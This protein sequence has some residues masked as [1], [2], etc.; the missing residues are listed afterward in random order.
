MHLKI[1]FI[2]VIF[3]SGIMPAMS[4]DNTLVYGLRTGM[5][6]GSF[7]GASAGSFSVPTSMEGVVKFGQS[8]TTA[9][10]VKGTFS[11]ESE[12]GKVKYLYSGGGQR[13]YL[14]SRFKGV[15]INT[16]DYSIRVMPRI[17]YYVGWDLGLAQIQVSEVSV[18]AGVSATVLEYGGMAGLTYKVTE[19]IGAEV[20]LSM[21]KG[22]SISSVQVDSTVIRLLLGASLF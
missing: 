1:V 11:L 3:F 2:L 10:V 8:P 16:D 20:I 4:A 7:T 6:M 21:S 9:Q 15:D 19:K 14:Y 5:V 22:L 18:V 17:Q 13:Y 12:T